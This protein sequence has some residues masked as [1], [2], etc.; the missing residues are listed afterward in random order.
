MSNLVFENLDF[1]SK[2]PKIKQNLNLVPKPLKG[3]WY[4]VQYNDASLWLFE[5]SFNKIA[6]VEVYTDRI[7]MIDSDGKINDTREN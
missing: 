3:S 6:N 5:K 2:Y 7:I 4:E 1:F